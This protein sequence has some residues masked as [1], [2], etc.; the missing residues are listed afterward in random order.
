M[1]RNMKKL[2]GLLWTQCSSQL[3]STIKGLTAFSDMYDD[4]NIVWL[5]TE[6]N[7]SKSGIDSKLDPRLTFHRA[8]AELYRLKQGE[9]ESNDRFLERFQ[10]AVNTVELTEGKRIFCIESMA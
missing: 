4:L 7:K 5:V 10:S 8:L 9:T 1:R 6:V 3:Q 2:F